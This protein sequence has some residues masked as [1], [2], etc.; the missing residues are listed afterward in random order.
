M[1]IMAA[2]DAVRTLGEGSDVP[3]EVVSDS[4]YVV[5]CFRDR[6]WDGWIKR[7]WR[8]AA[9][10]PV[11]NRDLWEP[12]VELV[13]SRTGTSGAVGFRWV[14]G[15]SGD[16]MNERVD[17]LAVAACNAQSP[18]TIVGLGSAVSAA[19]ASSENDGSSPAP[20]VMRLFDV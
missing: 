15:H 14:R 4:T 10:Q 1:E 16:P 19:T 2:F 12:F 6:W 17:R 11:A 3:I 7:G 9:K 18:R 5:N 8:N 13:R 20:S